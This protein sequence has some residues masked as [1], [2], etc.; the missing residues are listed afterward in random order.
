MD[1]IEYRIYDNSGQGGYV[2][3][4]EKGGNRVC[5]YLDYLD[6]AHGPY[7]L[8]DEAMIGWKY[9]TTLYA[10]EGNFKKDHPEYFL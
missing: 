9:I 2:L 4:W 1:K 7:Y 3:V 10:K 6:T 8:R 5:S